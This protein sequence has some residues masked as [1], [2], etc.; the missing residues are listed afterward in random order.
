MVGGELR[1]RLHSECRSESSVKNSVQ[2]RLPKA[3]AD[4]PDKEIDTV[5][6][7]ATQQP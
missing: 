5:G 4:S 3:L 2:L 7:S 1:E 6:S